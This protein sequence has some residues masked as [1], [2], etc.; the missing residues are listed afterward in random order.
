MK[1]LIATA[2]MMTS[3]S[4]FAAEMG[5]VDSF[6]SILPVGNYFGS[7]DKDGR[8]IV[9]VNEVNFPDKAIAVSISNIDNKVFKVISDGSIFSF[10]ANK[11]EFIQSERYDIDSSRNAYIDKIVKTVKAGDDRLY[12]IVAN[13]LTNNR[14]HTVEAIECVIVT[15]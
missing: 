12:V 10:R 6:L 2:L 11:N 3:L 9:S 15:K 5:A 7:N 4:A 14:T 13:E 8:C 1:N